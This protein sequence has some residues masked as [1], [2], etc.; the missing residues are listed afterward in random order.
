MAPSDLPRDLA[1][2]T[3]LRENMD[4][5]DHLLGRHGAVLLRGFP[6]TSEKDFADV[7]DICC[8]HPLAYLYRS[9]PRSQVG[10][11]IYTATEY[12]PGLRIPFHAENA[13]Q[14]EWPLLLLFYC[15]LPAE[16]GGGQTPLADLE[17]V[18]ARIPRHIREE[19]FAKEIMYIR[20]YSKDID[21]PWQV[22][23]QTES[24]QDVETYCANHQIE[25]EWKGNDSLRTK[26]VCQALARNPRSGELVWFNQ[27][28][29]F[30]PSSLDKRTRTLLESMYSSENLPRNA[31][32][33]DGSALDE[34]DLS[35]IRD[36][37]DAEARE[38]DWQAGDVLLLENMKVAHARNPYK[39]RR[40]VLT[41]MGR[42][43]SETT[44]V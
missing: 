14:R 38:F 7:V 26:Q 40:R 1:V 34:R 21:L 25:C 11:N 42:L 28:H 35:V 18:T 23:F 17:R 15:A 3:W 24:K 5:V 10:D 20:N 36:A 22:V 6:L 13:F 12:P 19:F 31:T 30:H 8:G 2:S 29:L 4:R 44:A 33:G 43:S 16:G 27:A 37:F 9:T 39:G 41:A 32:F